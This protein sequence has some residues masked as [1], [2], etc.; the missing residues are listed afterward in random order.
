MG[1]L[2]FT[3]A[4]IIGHIRAKEKVLD[5]ILNDGFTE[6]Y[7]PDFRIISPS[8]EPDVL[9]IENAPLKKKAILDFPIAYLDP[10]VDSRSFVITA[11]YLAERARQEKLNVYSLNS[12][13]AEREGKGILFY[14]N[15]SNLGKTTFASSLLKLGFRQ[16]SDEKTLLDLENLTLFSGSRSIPLR[17]EVLIKRFGDVRDFK[18]L[19]LIDLERPPALDLLISPHYDHGTV[20]PIV[21]ILKPLDILWNISGAISRRIRGVTRFIDNFTYQLPSLDT[22][23]LTDRRLKLITKL[24]ERVRA[25]YFQ[26]DSDQLI[27]Y[28]EENL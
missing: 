6:H 9:V 28:L 16:F 15:A 19:D 14:G 8:S 3:T 11:E 10:S 25:I 22:E 2:A 17:K 1:L 20:G 7:L 24:S 21:N 26:G 23:E 27:R 4:G 13:S 12:A 5:Q 18:K